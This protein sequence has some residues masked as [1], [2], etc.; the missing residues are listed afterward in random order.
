MLLIFFHKLPLAWASGQVEKK[1]T[2]FSQII[3]IELIP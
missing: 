3:N 2:G 1:Y